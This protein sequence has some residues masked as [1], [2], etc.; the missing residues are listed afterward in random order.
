MFRGSLLF[1]YGL[2]LLSD[3]GNSG[4]VTVVPRVWTGRQSIRS[5]FPTEAVLP[6]VWQVQREAD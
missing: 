3:A 6:G 1:A 2:E 5:S 4:S